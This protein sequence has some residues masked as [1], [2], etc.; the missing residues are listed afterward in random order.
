MMWREV[1]C[2]EQEEGPEVEYHK[3]SKPHLI[4]WTDIFDIILASAGKLM[5]QNKGV[6]I[7]PHHTNLVAARSRAMVYTSL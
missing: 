1:R 7:Q 4:Q 3:F 6:S 5:R 2:H